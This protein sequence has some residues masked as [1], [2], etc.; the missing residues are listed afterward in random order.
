MAIDGEIV[1]QW[2]VTPGFFLKA[3]DLPAGRLDG[4]GVWAT[5][6]LQSTPVSGAAVVQ[7]AIE[8]FDLQDANATMWAYDEGW[9]EAEFNQTLGVWRWTSDRATIRIAGPA[10]AVRIVMTIESPLRYF[11]EAPSVTARAG[12]RE[13]AST[14]LNAS[15]QWSFD[16]P[17][18]A[19]AKS[20]GVVAIETSKT[21]V[22]AAG[23]SAADQRKLGLRVF[24][25][26]VST[27]LTGPETTR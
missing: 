20:G 23:G 19:I 21:F 3:F 11:D 2:E 25:I 12:D 27:E 5:L 7:T 14:M 6:T 24:A 13:I 1:E 22:P 8:Q 18:E 9:Q 16:V 10:R 26:H 17:A 15:G 4:P